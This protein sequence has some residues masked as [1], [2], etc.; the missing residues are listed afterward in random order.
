[1][2]RLVDI[3]V[4]CLKIEGRTKSHYYVARTAQAYRQAID[5]A[6]AGKPLDPRLIGVLENLAHRGY[7]DG[8]YQRHHTQ[9]HQNYITGASQ[10]HKQEF[11]GEVIARNGDWFRVDV[12][13]KFS[14]G[15]KLEFILP[16]GQNREVVLSSLKDDKGNDISVAAGNGH[17]VHIP[18]H[19]I[20]SDMVLI[21]R[22][23]QPSEKQAA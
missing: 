9:D 17:I 5:M 10:T 15:D 1:V 11:V 3:G 13:N 16:S 8:F 2:Q 19:G 21:S 20:D 4:D 6:A 23:L 18:T 7:T 14:V 22:F 12:K